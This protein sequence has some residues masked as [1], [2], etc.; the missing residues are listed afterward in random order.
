MTDNP[1][2]GWG[3]RTQQPVFIAGPAYPE[4]LVV[5]EAS[6]KLTIP[7][8]WAP[9]IPPGVLNVKGHA[10]FVMFHWPWSEHGDLESH[11][12]IGLN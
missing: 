5:I 4:A 11:M 1:F 9:G 8:S 7:R 12:F 6:G 10:P 2:E 3:D